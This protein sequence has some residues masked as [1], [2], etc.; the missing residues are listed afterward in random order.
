MNASDVMTR[1]VIS[2][3][4]DM[5][6]SKL[7]NLLLTRNISG[8]PV[9]TEEGQL[10]GI[11]TEGDLVR[12]AELGTERKR[13][14]WLSFFTGTAAL[15]HDYVRS[16]GTKVRDVMTESVVA[17]TPETPVAEV[18]DLM[19]ERRIRRVP[20]VKD[21]KVVGIV[22]RQNLLRA[23]ASL[24]SETASVSASDHEIRERL[25]TELSRQNWSRRPENSIVVT[26]GVVHLWG[27]AGS[28][29]EKRAVELAAERTPGAKE[30]RNHIV[31]LEATPYP[32]LVGT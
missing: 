15:A 7:V 12:R 32:L 2:V 29:E 1:D 27:L 25:I 23:W 18:A 31:V 11:V 16:H 26:D 22:S 6:V 10:V 8:T 24:P 4:P 21:G 13:G 3:T 30:V 9:V 28:E 5:P 20:V 14:A 17:V 19:E